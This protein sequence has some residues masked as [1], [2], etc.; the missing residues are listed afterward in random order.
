VKI[1]PNPSQ[2]WLKKIL[3]D[4][5]KLAEQ[6]NGW[7]NHVGLSQS[8]AA[9]LLNLPVRT[10]Q[11][12]E[13]GRGFRYPVMLWTSMLHIDNEFDEMR[14]YTPEQNRIAMQEQARAATLLK[15]WGK[16]DG[17]AS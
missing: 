9:Y 8:E 11:G 4:P 13:Q 5:E 15:Q 2:E 10:L 6:V 14:H 12:I 16:S 3:A 17:Q 1:T 7:R